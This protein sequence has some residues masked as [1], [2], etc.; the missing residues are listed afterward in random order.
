MIA[1]WSWL[2]CCATYLVGNQL[3]Q[4]RAGPQY[5]LD[6]GSN[7]GAPLGLAGAPAAAARAGAAGGAGRGDGLR[8]GCQRSVLVPSEACCHQRSGRSAVRL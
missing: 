2:A 7:I 1:W 4:H 6:T 3:L 5:I 8:C